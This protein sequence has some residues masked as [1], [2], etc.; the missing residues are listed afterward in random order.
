MGKYTVDHV[1]KVWDDQNGTHVY[2][3]PDGDGL[4]LAEL[5]YVD[6]D[7]KIGDR[8]ALPKEMMVEVARAV[9]ALYGDKH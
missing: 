7:G 4:E 1:I 3:G 2:V 8:I 9:L 6:E 5:R